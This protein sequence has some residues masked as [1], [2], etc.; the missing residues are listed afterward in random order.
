MRQ[1]MQRYKAY[2]EVFLANPKSEEVSR[3]RRETLQQ[4]QFM[5][6]ERLVHFLVTMLVGILFLL[7]VGLYL[8]YATLGLLVLTILFLG[9][10][11]PYLWHYYFLENTTQQ[12][13]I[14]YNRLAE[15]EDGLAYP[16]TDTLGRI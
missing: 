16:N 11:A 1:Y 9:L 5:Q 3:L 4:I 7:S 10:L 8:C 14:L 13:Y 15:L 6:H 2:L 12:M